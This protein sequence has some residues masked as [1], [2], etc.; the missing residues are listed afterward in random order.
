MANVDLHGIEFKRIA[1]QLPPLAVG[2]TT[3]VGLVGAAPDAAGEASAVIVGAGDAALTVTAV[4]AG[5]AGDDL[6]I[7]IA[8]GGGALAIAVANGEIQVT[9]AAASTA[10]QVI[11]AINAS[12]DASALVTASLPSTS[13]GTGV[14]A[15]VAETSLAGGEDPALA[16][17]TPVLLTTAAQIASIGDAGSLPA[18]VRDVFLTAG[19][20]GATVIVVRT[21]DDAAATLAGVRAD[22]TGVYALLTAESET[23]QRP[24]LIAAPGAKDAVI[25]TALEAVATELRSIGVVTLAGATSAVAIVANPDSP[26]I[27][28]CWPE[29]VIADGTATT[30]RPA[31]ALVIGHF[32]RTDRNASFAASPSNRIMLGVLRSAVGVEWALGSRTTAANT[33]N[34]GNVTTFIRRGNNVYLW[35]NRLSDGAFVTTTRADEIISD[36]VA[37]AILDYLDRRVDLPF[38]EHIL[39][40]INGYLRNLIVN[41]HLRGGRAWF[42]PAF[43]TPDTLAAGQVTFSYEVTPHEIAEHIVFRASIGGLPNEVLAGL[44]Q[45]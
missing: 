6:S 17:D 34:Q 37:A 35:G 11:A 4:D 26:H 15:A 19:R 14:V 27:F 31:D 30:R 7:S 24:R 39:G 40:R 8:A 41:G 23:G 13:D 20:G 21:A 12:A 28:A 32:V 45:Q 16:L 44:A 33:L 10:A 25:T 22:R 42:D 3:T 36:E 43:N 1:S 29:L 2:L 5:V 18:A 9:P 38:V